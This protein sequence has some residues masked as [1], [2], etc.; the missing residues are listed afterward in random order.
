MAK[1]NIKETT[2]S[3]AILK[4]GGPYQF[5]RKLAEAVGADDF[6]LQYGDK[7]FVERAVSGRNTYGV[8]EGGQKAWHEKDNPM[9]KGF[10]GG[11]FVVGRDK[12]G[13]VASSSLIGK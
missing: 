4:A 1:N 10:I 8:W 6:L 9:G 11:K 7:G 2:V 3:L 12:K 13:I 5:W